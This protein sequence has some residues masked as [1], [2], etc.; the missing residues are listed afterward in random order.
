MLVHQKVTCIV[1]SMAIVSWDEQSG[2]PPP[3]FQQN[4]GVR[5][6]NS[7]LNQP[8]P[9]ENRA[10]MVCHPI[11]PDRPSHPNGPNSLCYQHWRLYFSLS[12]LSRTWR[13]F[14]HMTH[15]GMTYHY[16]IDCIPICL[17][18]WAV[19]LFYPRP[20]QTIFRGRPTP[21]ETVTG[22]NRCGYA[23]WFTYCQ[24]M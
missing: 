22:R 21:A 24:W 12:H 3:K 1:Q 6:R 14:I 5:T 16:V 11:H 10:M 13:W 7:G 17:V 19:S 23:S 9:T 20:E 2:S 4:R 8:V 15:T 18:Y